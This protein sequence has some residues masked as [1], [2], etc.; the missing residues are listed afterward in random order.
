V[1][2]SNNFGSGYTT[3]T[4]LSISTYTTTS[5][6]PAE[7]TARAFHRIVFMPTPPVVQEEAEEELDQGRGKLLE[8]E[9]AK[10]REHIKVLVR[11][12]S[13]LERWL[14]ELRVGWLL[15]P[16]PGVGELDA[17]ASQRFQYCAESWILAVYVISRSIS[18]FNGW[19]CP[20]GSEEE[21]AA[22]W[23]S[24]SEL[25][26]FVVA[27]LLKM[28]PFADTVVT[29]N[30]TDPLTTEEP[31]SKLGA[32][33]VPPADKFQALVDVRDALSRV[34]QGLQLWASWLCS[35]SPD[36]EAAGRI[37]EMD[38]ILFAE[39][40]KLDEAIWE[41]RHYMVSRIMSLMD[42]SP[43]GWGGARGH[44]RSAE[45][46]KAARSITS[47]INVLSTSY[48][49]SLNHQ[50]KNTSPLSRL[51]TE[52]VHSLE[53]KI[54]RKSLSFQDRGL[55]FLFLI[56]NFYFMRQ[57]LG[58]NRLLNVPMRALTLKID[59][60][61]N[62]Y[63]LVSWAPVLKCLHNRATPCCFTTYSPLLEFESEFQRTHRTQKLWK[64][65]DPKLR[66]RLR[67]AIIEEV[68]TG[69][70]KFL[71]DNSIS[72]PQVSPDNLEEM[73]QELFEG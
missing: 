67:K 16:T 57:Q 1:E 60:C 68:I 62:N 35:S 58:A 37:S 25:V 36:A 17:S 49:G 50:P 54:A 22:G 66:K 18:S 26:R 73:L 23:P 29:V 11:G 12:A 20:Q 28:L 10:T 61:I 34:S 15:D 56:N 31:C 7:E 69:I 39:L 51:T 21:A 65:P 47:Y 38:N 5:S 3:G 2:S 24:A 53:E 41:T 64:V 71:E 45:I 13:G 33:A 30:I 70:T 46:H 8:E 72:T 40:G 42:D 59:E 63:I 48:D 19:C 27:T 4:T 43:S 14:S 52:M 9:R 32:A 44:Q 6:D 55:R